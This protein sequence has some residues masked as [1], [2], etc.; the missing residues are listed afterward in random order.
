MATTDALEKEEGSKL[1]AEREMITKDLQNK[2][3]RKT[4]DDGES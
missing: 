1:D 4:P 3:E 2:K